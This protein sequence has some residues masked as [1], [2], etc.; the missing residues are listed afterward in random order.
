MLR[1]GTARNQLQLCDEIDSRSPAVARTRTIRVIRV[2]GRIQRAARGRCR[3]RGGGE[4]RSDGAA[5]GDPERVT[6]LV[7][8]AVLGAE[9]GAVVY[10]EK[11]GGRQR[12]LP[13]VNSLSNN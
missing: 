12:R 1:A 2:L 5:H 3:V 13:R 4:G 10:A 6:R 9:M 7:R 8:A 11:V